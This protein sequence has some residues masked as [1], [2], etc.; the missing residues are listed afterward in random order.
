[1]TLQEIKDA[2]DSG[3]A[4]CCGNDFYRVIK[5]G[6]GYLIVCT[7]NNY[8]IGLTW[9]NGITLNDKEESFYIKPNME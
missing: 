7:A 1:M 2:V 4:V 5:G 9:Q 3:E 6:G 8:A